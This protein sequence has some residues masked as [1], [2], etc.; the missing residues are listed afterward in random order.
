MQKEKPKMTIGLSG[1]DKFRL[2][3]KC[4]KYKIGI[5]EIKCMGNDIIEKWDD[6]LAVAFDTCFVD[7]GTE[8]VFLIR[9]C[10]SHLSGSGRECNIG[11]RHTGKS[12]LNQN[13]R[14]RKYV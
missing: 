8:Q 11:I 6:V 5:G 1:S 13:G 14:N 10:N 12:K 9:E 4:R 3:E 2:S 7:C